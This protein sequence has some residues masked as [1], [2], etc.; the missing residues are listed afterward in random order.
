MNC[1]PLIVSDDI[2]RDNTNTSIIKRYGERG[3]LGGLHVQW[4]RN[5]TGSHYSF[6][7]VIKQVNPAIKSFSKV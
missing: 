4:E 2:L 5:L 1:M 7:V 6:G 3:Q